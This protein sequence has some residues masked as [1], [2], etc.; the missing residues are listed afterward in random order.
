MLSH[1]LDEPRGSMAP[2]HSGE[3]PGLVGTESSAKFM[4]NLCIL[5][6]IPFLVLHLFPFKNEEYQ[7]SGGTVMEEDA[8]VLPLSDPSPPCP[9]T[10]S[11]L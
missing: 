11:C 8:V 1:G 6:F 3:P 4:I 10:A 7:R 9:P 5:N 2:L